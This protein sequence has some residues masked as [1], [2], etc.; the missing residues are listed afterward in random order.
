MEKDA[1]EIQA[2]ISD[3]NQ[4]VAPAAPLSFAFGFGL[5]CVK[6]PFTGAHDGLARAIFLDAID[7]HLRGA[8]HKIHMGD[9]RVAARGVE[10]FIGQF[11]AAGQSEAIGAPDR[12][13]TGGILIEERVV[14]EMT[15]S[16]NR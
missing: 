2:L 11:L 8:D 10:L 16:R 13:V 3:V 4:K 15:A 1:A 12:N 7:V 6:C 5:F 14:K 9:A